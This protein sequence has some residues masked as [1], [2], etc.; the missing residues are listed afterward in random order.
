LL[1]NNQARSA[2]ESRY[3]QVWDWDTIATYA[4]TTVHSKGRKLKTTGL[5][6]YANP[7]DDLAQRYPF[8]SLFDTNSDA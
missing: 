8:F 4:R 2:W 5:K 7:V 3:L 6:G 1:W